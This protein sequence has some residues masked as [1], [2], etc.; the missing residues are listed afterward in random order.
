MHDIRDVDRQSNGRPREGGARDVWV[1]E[2]ADGGTPRKRGFAK[3]YIPVRDDSPR[4]T[5][6]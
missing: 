3:R 4:Q 2:G 1:G 6:A 5:R